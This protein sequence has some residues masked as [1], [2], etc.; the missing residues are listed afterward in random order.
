MLI[1]EYIIKIKMSNSSIIWVYPDP[2]PE[3]GVRQGC[4]V[5]MFVALSSLL[6]RLT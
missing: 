2:F 6:V 3:F 5:W 1:N 4:D